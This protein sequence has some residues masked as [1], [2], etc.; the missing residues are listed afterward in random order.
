MYG[1]AGFPS[2]PVQNFINTGIEIEGKILSDNEDVS[3]MLVRCKT[4][5]ID[6]KNS[7]VYIKEI[8]GSISKTY[9]I[10]IPKDEKDIRIENLEKELEEMKELINGYSKYSKPVDDVEQSDTVNNG[11]VKSSTKKSSKSVS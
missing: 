3:N 9:D 8:N 10:V 2:A 1:Y 6:E 11:D 7:K 5:F 4:I